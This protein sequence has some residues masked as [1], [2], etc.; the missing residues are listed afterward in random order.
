MQNLLYNIS[1][2]L[3]TTILH[4]L[5]QGL[6]ILV[7]L[8]LFLLVKPATSAAIK[9]WVSYAALCIILG[10]FIVTLFNQLGQYE[11]LSTTA[12]QIPPLTLPVVNIP[13]SKPYFTI[14]Q[15]MPYLAV[16]YVMGLIFN[17]LKLCLA[18]NSIYR[19][20]Q[21][22]SEAGFEHI[23]SRLS[24]QLNITKFV[25]AAFSEWVNVPC[26][27]GFIKPI[28]LLPVSITCHLSTPEIEAILFH[29]LAHIK[30]ND[31]LLN[32]IQQVIGILL[33]FNPF[34]RLITKIIN[35]ERENCC[36]DVVIQVTGSPFIYAQALLKLQESKQQTRWQLA[37]AAKTKKYELLNRIER[38]MK[39]K[40]PT[41]NIRPVLIT[42]LA[43]TCAISSIAWLN[44]E[45]K[46]GK[47]VI[48]NAPAIHKVTTAILTPET[49][50][51]KP[52]KPIRKHKKSITFK[53]VADTAQT[54]AVDDT[55]IK[56]K[57]YKIVIEDENGNKKEYNSLKEL[58]EKD[59]ND[60]L[61]KSAGFKF[62][63]IDSNAF[64]DL[65]KFYTSDHWKKQVEE[66]QK[67]GLAMSKKMNTPEFKKFQK[68]IAA[69]SLAM[70]KQFNS[71]EF[72]K[73]QK[74]M[75]EKT[76]EF[77]KKVY[78]PEMQKMAE[79]LAKKGANPDYYNSPEFKDQLENL[80][81][82]Y[83]S[84]EFKDGI[85][86]M[87]DYY[88][89]PDFKNQMKKV[90]DYYN[91]PEFKKQIKKMTQNYDSPKFKKQMEK[92]GKSFE[93]IRGNQLDNTSKQGTDSDEGKHPTDTVNQ[94]P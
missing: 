87:T 73:L 49:I 88:N 65:H 63:R 35:Q 43:L 28:I 37:L 32:F 26:V 92:M 14:A 24:N 81:K 91:S 74:E 16:L 38:I 64:T 51:T 62:D 68:K 3:G 12:L 93:D 34:A 66:A 31:Y 17:I 72:K 27:T 29:E 36:D 82:Y 39:T 10:W 69:Q 11:W 77:A 19:I 67:M 83:D 75:T 33:F 60:F 94:K 50:V 46:N 18:W 90:T 52:A 53:Y 9:Y 25:K 71:P 61:G 55:I 80:G 20:R 48:K 84:Q 79:N 54:T 85:K 45:I 76:A 2:V 30:R 42:V 4:S 15:F 59:R 58:P 41:V 1:Q 22:I 6:I 23:V 89:S 56:N 78:G 44:P 70:S 8:R 21:N 13:V 86:K 40:T 5:W 7:S 57:K 47:I